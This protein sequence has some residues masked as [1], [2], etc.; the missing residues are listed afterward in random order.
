MKPITTDQMR[1]MTNAQVFEQ[2]KTMTVDER[3]QFEITMFQEL[4]TMLAEYNKFDIFKNN[5]LTIKTL[6]N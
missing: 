5:Y 4:S 2:M 1:K 6:F 3:K